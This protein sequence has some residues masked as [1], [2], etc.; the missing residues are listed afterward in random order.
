MTREPRAQHIPSVLFLTATLF[1][2]LV[3]KEKRKR[4][5]K[6]P[7]AKTTLHTL[8]PGHSDSLMTPSPQPTKDTQVT[9]GLCEV[10]GVYCGVLDWT[11]GLKLELWG[12]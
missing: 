5:S 12:K 6:M 3:K 11:G 4:A 2:P 8:F 9:Y 7:S 10:E 1:N